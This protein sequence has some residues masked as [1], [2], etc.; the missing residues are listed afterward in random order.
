MYC[1]SQRCVNIVNTDVTTMYMFC[2]PP[3]CVPAPPGACLPVRGSQF[4]GF[5][6]TKKLGRCEIG[7]CARALRV[8]QQLQPSACGVCATTGG[9]ARGA[10]ATGYTTTPRETTPRRARVRA[11]AAAAAANSGP[12][13]TI[14]LL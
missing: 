8:E 4:W 6:S 2:V 5:M 10:R 11:A 13:G 14:G 7:V 3:M 12:I 9:A 1:T